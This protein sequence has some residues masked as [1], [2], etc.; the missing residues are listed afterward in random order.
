MGF[1][2]KLAPG[3]RV[4]ASSRG[5]R[6]SLGPRIARLHVG[7][8]RPGI[9][10]GAGPVSYYTG[11]GGAGGPRSTSRSRTGTAAANRQQAASARAADKQVAARALNEAIQSIV[12]SHR[13]RF[14]SAEPPVAPPP[15]LI[16]LGSIRAKH[17]R[18]ARAAT[19][20]F[21]RAARRAALAEAERR[22]QV[23]VA[24][25]SEYYEKERAGWQRSMDAHWT[26]LRLTMPIPSWLSWRT[27][28][29]TTKHQPQP[30]AWKALK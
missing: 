14:P 8:G 6:T 23:E 2:V 7:A 30:L 28:S 24:T 21:S 15:P 20:V 19:S 27:P 5:V 16:D 22:T 9:S 3:V 12:N 10:T 4:R 18:E 25:V 17:A 29:R 26:A 1:Y 11:F 13:T